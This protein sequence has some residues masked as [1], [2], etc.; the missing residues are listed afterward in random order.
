MGSL[1]MGG[2]ST[3]IAFKLNEAANLSVPFHTNEV[4]FNHT[5]PVYARSYLCYGHVE[6]EARFLG[7]LVYTQVSRGRLCWEWQGRSQV[8]GFRGNCCFT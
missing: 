5:Y 8:L 3:E 7:H 1:D 2:A 6:A 4:L